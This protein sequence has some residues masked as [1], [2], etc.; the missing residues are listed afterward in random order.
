[1]ITIIGIIL[2]F[3][4]GILSNYVS[5]LPIHFPF[6]LFFV[7]LY[8]LF[9]QIVFP[10]KR[11]ELL[12]L[13]FGLGILYDICYTNVYFLHSLLFCFCC[14]LFQ[15]LEKKNSIPIIHFFFLFFCYCSLEYLFSILFTT[16][17]FSFYYYFSYLMQMFFSNILLLCIF[18]FFS[19]RKKL[20]SGIYF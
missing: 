16:T 8:L 19:K 6:K 1:M 2:L 7:F 5:F 4:E 9:L 11:K 20:Q 18:S 13:S 14:Y 3:L 10:Q 12:Y 15:L 17:Y